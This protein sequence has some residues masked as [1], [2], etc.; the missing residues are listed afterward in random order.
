MGPG[1]FA[2]VTTS[3]P[4]IAKVI[5]NRLLR[6]R[7]LP[8]LPPQISTPTPKSEDKNGT[9]VHTHTHTYTHSCHSFVT[10]SAFCMMKGLAQS[11]ITQLLGGIW[12]A[13]QS[14]PLPAFKVSRAVL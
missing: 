3:A 13:S 11:I 9:Y 8:P 6:F 4:N 1:N 2:F 12:E 14:S 5:S 7:K 10:T